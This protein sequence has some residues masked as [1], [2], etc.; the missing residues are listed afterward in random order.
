MP[1]R[2][3]TPGRPTLRQGKA[4]QKMFG[5]RPRGDTAGEILPVPPL[6]KEGIQKPPLVKGAAR[7]AGGFGT[8]AVM[9]RTFASS[10]STRETPAV[11]HGRPRLCQHS[12]ELVDLLQATGNHD[13]HSFQKE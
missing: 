13:G 1:S 4:R 11:L 6:L 3:T 5:V 12:L 2:A 9:T 7:S 8:G 10:I